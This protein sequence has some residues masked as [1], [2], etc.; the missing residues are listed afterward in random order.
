MLLRCVIFSNQ[1]L[2]A[3]II[4]SDS[5]RLAAWVI[6][7]T[8]QQLLWVIPGLFLHI[9]LAWLVRRCQRRRIWIR[10]QTVRGMGEQGRVG[11][12]MLLLLLYLILYH[13]QRRCKDTLLIV[14]LA[15]FSWCFIAEFRFEEVDIGLNIRIRTLITGTFLCGIP[16]N[17]S[18]V[19]GAYEVD[20]AAGLLRYNLQLLNIFLKSKGLLQWVWSAIH[21]V[22]AFRSI[23]IFVGHRV[24]PT[25]RDRWITAGSLALN[26]AE[27]TL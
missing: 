22:G 4:F 10:W 8:P 9:R 14:L 19:L 3:S 6:L 15:A 13:R 1:Q 7:L 21:E 12:I 20:V 16:L 18:Q 26:V 11:A 24:K 17:I 5:G 27:I 2:F 25:D 23:C